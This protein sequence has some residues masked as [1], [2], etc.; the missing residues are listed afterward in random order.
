MNSSVNSIVYFLEGAED[1]R[2]DV[3]MGD[4]YGKT[5]YIYNL[6][7][8][9]DGGRVTLYIREETAEMTDYLNSFEG[10]NDVS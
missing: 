5:F 4:G 9:N 2:I 6:R 7:I 3:R 1:T 10:T 8:P